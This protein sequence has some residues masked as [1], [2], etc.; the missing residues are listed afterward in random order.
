MQDK[1]KNFLSGLSGVGIGILV[2]VGFVLL[3]I[4]GAKLFEA[5]YPFLQRL[6]FI[7]W[8][9]VGLLLILSIVPSFRKFTGNGIILGTYV[10]GI[11]FWFLCFYITYSLW[12]LLGVF[13]GVIFLGLGIVPTAILALLFSGQFAQAFGF[14]LNA[15]LILLFRYLGFIILSKYKPSQLQDLEKRSEEEIQK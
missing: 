1:N 8:N 5:L 2:I 10:G 9:I 11:I 7:V 13:I 6:S 15:F 4:G 3:I 14:I 12:G